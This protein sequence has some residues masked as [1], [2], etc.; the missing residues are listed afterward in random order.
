MYGSDLWKYSGHEVEQMYV[1]WCKVVRRLWKIPAATY[2]NLLTIDN[3][4]LKV[5]LYAIAFGIALTFLIVWEL[6]AISSIS[7]LHQC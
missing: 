5:S 6:I 3:G 2:C 4:T 7:T 1:A